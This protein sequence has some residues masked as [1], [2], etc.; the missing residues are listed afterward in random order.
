MGWQSERDLKWEHVAKTLGQVP[1]LTFENA[2]F[3]QVEVGRR[4][5]TSGW[6]PSSSE[7]RDQV[8]PMKATTDSQDKSLPLPNPFFPDPDAYVTV[9]SEL[10]NSRFPNPVTVIL[11][12]TAR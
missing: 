2:T 1:K 7:G 11:T 12:V 10:I 3:A 6:R 8:A 9:A 4:V 5:V